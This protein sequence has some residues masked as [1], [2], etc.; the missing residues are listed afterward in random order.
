MR[1]SLDK[2]GMKKDK[3]EQGWGLERMR[4][5]GMRLHVLSLMIYGE[6]ACKV[7]TNSTFNIC[8]NF[9]NKFKHHR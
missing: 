4:M 5:N 2:N 9:L 1:M 6:L 8:P 3:D 7:V